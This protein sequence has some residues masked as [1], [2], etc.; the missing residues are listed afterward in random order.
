M[1]NPNDC[2]IFNG[3]LYYVGT[4]VQIKESQREKFRFNS[5]LVFKKYDSENCT[6]YFASPYDIWEQYPIF[7]P[8]LSMYIE[9]I[10]RA[11]APPVTEKKVQMKY[12]DGI[13]SAWIWYILLMLFACIL[14]DA[15]T[16]VFAWLVISFIFFRW[17][18]DKRQGK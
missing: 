7:A 13:V 10:L 1:G 9:S 3:K 8:Q 11:S 15:S 6:C 2:F 18:H 4:M 14:K 5:R 12:I 16:V 17:L